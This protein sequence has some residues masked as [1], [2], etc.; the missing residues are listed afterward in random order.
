MGDWLGTGNRRGGWR[1]FEDARAFARGLK[2]KSVTEWYDY[3]KSGK[4]PH[5]IPTSPRNSY[6]NVGWAGYDNWLGTERVSLRHV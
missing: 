2:L 1:N 6:A 4:K 3:C 5:D